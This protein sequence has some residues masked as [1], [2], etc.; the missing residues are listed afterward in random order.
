MWCMFMAI[1]GH[2]VQSPIE[3]YGA[4][5]ESLV[6]LGSVWCQLFEL[7]CLPDKVTSYL[8]KLHTK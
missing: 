1:S 2:G 3:M 7:A 8:L 5:K 6:V 4:T